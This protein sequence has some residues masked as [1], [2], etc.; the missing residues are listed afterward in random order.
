M[1]IKLLTRLFWIS[2][3]L[4][5]LAYAASAQTIVDDGHKVLCSSFPDGAEILID[6]VD[7]GLQTPAEIPHIPP[8]KHVLS[9][10]EPGWNSTSVTINV[11]DVDATGKPRDTHISLSM[12]PSL[13]VGATGPAGP[14]GAPGVP[15]PQGPIGPIGPQGPMGL[16]VQGPPGVPGGV[17]PQGPSGAIGPQGPSGSPG[18]PGPAGSPGAQGPQGVDGAPG[19][20]GPPGPAGALSSPLYTTVT[21]PTAC[22]HFW[23]NPPESLTLTSDTPRQALV[24][25]STSLTSQ[26][27]SQAWLGF[28][29]TG[30]TAHNNGTDESVGGN[31]ASTQNVFGGSRMVLV[32]LNPGS[33]TFTPQFWNECGNQFTAPSLLVLPF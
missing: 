6:G 5:L 4:L 14:Q 32:N 31:A 12:L 15:G 21:A 25:V 27:G 28:T 2:L 29:V 9:L 19:V 20:P 1:R 30:A 11:L 18:V 10:S 8:G 24:I 16:S 3:V 22:G 23:Q 17:G 7:T 13:T 26:S 33:N